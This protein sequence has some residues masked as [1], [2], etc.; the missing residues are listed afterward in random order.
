L[1]D[2]AP[3]S[4]RRARALAIALYVPILFLSFP[5]W[6]GGRAVDFGALLCWL[7][8]ALLLFS[9]RGLRPGAAARRAFLMSWVGHAA[10]LHWGYVVTVT[11]GNASAWLGALAPFGMASYVAA[12]TALA[13]FAWA[14]LARRRLAD[15]FVTAALFVVA[16]LLREFVGGGFPWAVIGYAQHQ[17]GWLLPW[18][19]LTGV[20]GLSFVTVLLAAALVEALAARRAGRSPGRSLWLPVAVVAIVLAVGWALSA[21]PA[22]EPRSYLRIAAVQGNID[23]GLKWSPGALQASLDRYE[24]L[25]LE[26]VADGAR[27]VVW[28]ETAVPGALELEPLAL[29]RVQA[30]ARRT[31]AGFVV[32]SVGV[33]VDRAAGEVTDYYDSAFAFDPQGRPVG[34]YDKSHLVPFGEYLPLR[35]LL[36]GLFETLAS[37]I[38]PMDVTPGAGPRAMRMPLSTGGWADG[39]GAADGGALRLGTPICYELLFPDLVRR[40]VLEGA[41]VLLAITN[42]AWYGRTGAPHQFLAMTAMR[43]AETG[44]WTV[45]AANTGVSAIIDGRGRVREQTGIFE[46]GFVIADVPLLDGQERV[47]RSFYVRHGNVFAWGCAAAIAVRIGIAGRKRGS[48]RGAEGES[49]SGAGRAARETDESNEGWS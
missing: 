20:Y 1:N 40:F 28:P 46:S 45:R 39:G 3:R 32:G 31:G 34:R 36:G 23:Q 41:E 42:D 26:A 37:G 47:G 12:I 35:D 2:G 13:G 22:P 33:A 43:S 4:G 18:A 16:D 21:R 8:P 6:L 15:P 7:A 44:A 25:S 48:A 19:A 29:A 24:Q 49:S 30:L 11:H 27:L 5:Q 17:N 10:I 38:A 9:L 14:W